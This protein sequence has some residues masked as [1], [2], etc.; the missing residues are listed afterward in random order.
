MVGSWEEQHIV[1]TL[2]ISFL[3]IVLHEL[4]DRATEPLPPRRV[5]GETGT[6]A[7]HVQ[8]VEPSDSRRTL[9]AADSVSAAD[10]TPTME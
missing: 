10:A 7:I 3:S 4:A 8:C 1:Q 9:F 2:M 6:P 5:M